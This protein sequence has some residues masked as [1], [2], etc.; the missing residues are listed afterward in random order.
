LREMISERFT[1]IFQSGALKE[2]HILQKNEDF[3]R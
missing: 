1:S 2:V 3:F